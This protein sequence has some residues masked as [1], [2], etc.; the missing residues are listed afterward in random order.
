LRFLD[1]VRFVLALAQ[2]ATARVRG[3]KL[4]AVVMMRNEISRNP[5]EDALASEI[6]ARRVASA[7]VTMSI[8][9]LISSLK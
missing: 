5:A 1:A 4:V 2:R 6:S 8:E 7:T 9:T 3:A